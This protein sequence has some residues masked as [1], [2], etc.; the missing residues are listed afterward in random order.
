V[1]FV[2]QS[3][4]KGHTKPLA[5]VAGA[6]D[7]AV[8][9]TAAHDQSLRVWDTTTWTCRHVLKDMDTGTSQPVFVLD[10]SPGAHFLATGVADFTTKVHSLASGERIARLHPELRNKFN[11]AEQIRFSP[12]GE[13]LACA[14]GKSV[15][16]FRVGR[17]EKAAEL[18]RH[19]SKVHL[20]AFAP[21]GKT[22]ITCGGK[23]IKLWDVACLAERS[24]ITRH[25]R[26]LA[27]LA[28]AENGGFFVTAGEDGAI[29]LWSLPGGDELGRYEGHDEEVFELAISPLGTVAASRG[30]S[31][32]LHLWDV[33][34][35]AMVAEVETDEGGGK[36]AFTP[37]GQWLLFFGESPATFV[38][39][40]GSG[41]EVQRLSPSPTG[42][43][44]PLGRW[45][46]LF[47]GNDLAIWAWN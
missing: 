23:S 1:S 30:M 2:R 27:S 16:L 32:R 7:G 18:K 9:V 13:Y 25:D 14:K 26:Q 41:R 21:D 10:V 22:L 15:D 28:V 11:A 6:P 34:T 17:F 24:T 31:G 37:N 19:T 46:A 8:L 45:V 29:F 3:T 35:G 42:F 43:V 39:D 44:D 38:L 12:S 40:S 33:R 4:L 20:L 5:A 47:E 36:L